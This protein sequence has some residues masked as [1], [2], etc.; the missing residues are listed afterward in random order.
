MTKWSEMN[1]EDILRQVIFF[2][3]LLN[4]MAQT[5]VQSDE[6]LLALVQ[7]YQMVLGVTKGNFL[8]LGNYV[9]HRGI[10]MMLSGAKATTSSLRIHPKGYLELSWG[11]IAYSLCPLPVDLHRLMLNCWQLRLLIH[12]DQ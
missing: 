11:K 1:L 4:P 3:I 5:L 9:D 7:S 10:K 6:M 2:F 8:S 12:V